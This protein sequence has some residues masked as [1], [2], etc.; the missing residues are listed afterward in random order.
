MKNSSMSTGRKISVTKQWHRLRSSPRMLYWKYRRKMLILNRPADMKIEYKT[1]PLDDIVQK[2]TLVV[3]VYMNNEKYLQEMLDY[4]SVMPAEVK[5][6]F[7]IILIDDCSP[8]A[9]R[10]KRNGLDIQIYRVLDDIPWNIPGAR[11]LGVMCS[12]TERFILLDLDHYLPQE[13]LIALSRVKL[14]DKDILLFKRY[15]DGREFRVHVGTFFMKKTLFLAL[16]GCDEDF[17][18]YYGSDG[19]LHACM[20]D[21]HCNLILC[22]LILCTDTAIDGSRQHDLVREREHNKKIMQRK[23]KSPLKLHSKKMLR[24]K[25]VKVL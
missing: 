23:N 24:F 12:D 18:G 11:N 2:F 4:Y 5:A 3:P 21:Y 19:H 7:R 25:W 8:V 20:A 6:L 10:A 1:V 17:A 15:K 22:D 9:V 16:Y 13:T 14:R